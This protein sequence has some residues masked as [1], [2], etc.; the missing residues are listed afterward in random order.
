MFLLKNVM[1]HKILCDPLIYYKSYEWI[2][3]KNLSCPIFTPQNQFS[4]II[5]I[6]T[7]N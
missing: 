6:F 5:D 2:N 3:Q 7:L 4:Y 1:I